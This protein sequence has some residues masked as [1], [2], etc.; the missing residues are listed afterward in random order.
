MHH[1]GFSPLLDLH[2]PFDCSSKSVSILR[3]AHTF[4]LFNDIVPMHHR[5][6]RLSQEFKDFFC[7]VLHLFLTDSGRDQRK[8]LWISS[9]YVVC[10]YDRCLMHK[11]LILVNSS[12]AQARKS[13]FILVFINNF[14]LGNIIQEMKWDWTLLFLEGWAEGI[15]WQYL[16]VSLLIW[17]KFGNQNLGHVPTS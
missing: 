13:D 4:E 2:P 15:D 11:N 8:G 1:V 16:S 9:M 14:S 6:P 12:M 17:A 7:I 3:V 5:N 10:R